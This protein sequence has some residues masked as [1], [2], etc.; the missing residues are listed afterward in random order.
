METYLLITILKMKAMAQILVSF[1]FSL[2]PKK[3][4]DYLNIKISAWLR[5][6]F[7]FASLGFSEWN[8]INVRHILGI[9]I[10]LMILLLSRVSYFF[11]FKCKKTLSESTE[12]DRLSFQGQITREI[13]EICQM[14]AHNN[15]H[16]HIVQYDL[17]LMA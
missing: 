14:A 3:G 1:P 7:H 2:N 5:N 17:G 8:Y 9:H 12:A 16:D 13:K 11:L 6:S 10:M 4:P 15:I